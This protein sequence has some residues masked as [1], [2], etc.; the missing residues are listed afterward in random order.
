MVAEIELF[1]LGITRAGA[2]CEEDGNCIL[3]SGRGFQSSQDALLNRLKD[4]LM[5]CFG[6]SQM[7]RR[8]S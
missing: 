6:R 2:I 1:L 5:D 3:I 7:S 4:L 8:P